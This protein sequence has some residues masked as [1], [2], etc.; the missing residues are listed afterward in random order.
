MNQIANAEHTPAVLT[1]EGAERRVLSYG[2]GLMLVQFRFPAGVTA[3][4]HSHPHE[5]IGY[6]V[7][8]AIDLLIEGREPVRL[9]QGA[10]YYVPPDVRHG[11]FTHFPTV[12]LD[13][14]TPLREDFLASMD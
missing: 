4:Q 8:G 6:V 13:C 14:F 7:E 11:I 1:P 12:L 3:P 9:E 5:Q 2:G 10:S